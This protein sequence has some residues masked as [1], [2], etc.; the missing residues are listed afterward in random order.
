MSLNDVAGTLNTT[1]VARRS[2]CS[3]AHADKPKERDQAFSQLLSQLL[4]GH[5]KHR[6]PPQATGLSEF[7]LHNITAQAA[8]P[9]AEAS[10]PNIDMYA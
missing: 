3:A 5:N 4:G 9:V 7:S 10:D 8:A 6:L 1:G 2:A